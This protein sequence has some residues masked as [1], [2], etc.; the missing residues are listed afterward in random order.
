MDTSQFDALYRDVPAEMRETLLEFRASHPYQHVEIK[1]VPW[2]YIACGQ[3]TQALLILGGGLSVGET[4]FTTILRMEKEFRILCPSYP[5]VGKMDVLADGLAAILDREN[6]PK[7]SILGH[8]LGSAVGHVFLRFYPERVDRLVLDGFGLY[9]PFHTWMAQ[10]FILLPYPALKS[11]YRRAFNRLLAHADKDERLFM[12]AYIEELFSTLHTRETFLGQ[13]NLLADI[14]THAEKY[15]VFEPVE[16]PGKVLLMLAE[17][18]HGFTPG[19]R[20]ALIATYP[21]A[22]IHRF[23][24]G[25]H[26]SELSHPEEFNAHLDGF[27]KMNS[28]PKA[29]NIP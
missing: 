11:Y 6:I 28:N 14:F 17:D 5:P 1:G 27:L 13:F 18:D 19:E 25:G 12:K 22:W 8:S 29:I 3:G 10:L 9:S 2:E 16:R 20:Q 24:S 21:D 4:S 26:L 15:R 7:S 23:T